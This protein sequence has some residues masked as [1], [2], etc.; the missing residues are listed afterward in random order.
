MKEQQHLF[1]DQSKQKIERI[2]DPA[3]PISRDDVVWMLGY[4]TKKVADEDPAIMGL[5]QPQ[6]LRN[7]HAYAEVSMAL[8]NRRN[9]SDQDVIRLREWLRQAATGLL[10]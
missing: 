8:I 5:S 2:L 10:S 3:Y 4:I 9:S 6:L 7:F 1:Q